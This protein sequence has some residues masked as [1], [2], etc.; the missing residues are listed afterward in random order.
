MEL[1]LRFEGGASDNLDPE[2]RRY[3]LVEMY[4]LFKV[5]DRDILF[6]EGNTQHPCPLAGCSSGRLRVM[7]DEQ[8]PDHD[9][10]FS[11]LGMEIR[12]ISPPD[13]PAQDWQVVYG[14]Q[15]IRPEINTMMIGD[16][17]LENV[18]VDPSEGLLPLPEN[19]PRGERFS[20]SQFDSYL[21]NLV[22]EL[23]TPQQLGQ[24]PRPVSAD[25]TQTF[26]GHAISEVSE[27]PSVPSDPCAE[28]GCD[29]RPWLAE[30]LTPE[31]LAAVLEAE[32]EEL[33]WLTANGGNPVLPETPCQRHIVLYGTLPGDISGP[34]GKPDCLV[35][36]YD[37][38]VIGDGWLQCIDGVNECL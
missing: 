22:S 2:G 20:E 3:L 13:V 5:G 31:Q 17:E 23:F 29:E 9:F 33:R 36:M 25:I 21:I 19:N 18:L 8:Y 26:Q 34:D 6:V 37:L 35:N 16:L 7:P 15:H 30:V 11:D 14:P 1:T 12:V 38:A 32:Q 27:P 24:L 28:G 4:P 10:I